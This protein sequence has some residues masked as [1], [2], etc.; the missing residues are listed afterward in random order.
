M[1]ASCSLSRARWFGAAAVASALAAAGSILVPL[2]AGAWLS[3]G[4]AL[5]AAALAAA[6]AVSLNRAGRWVRET[7]R[8]CDALARGDFE[9]RLVR[10]D[11][12]G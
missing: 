3:A 8:V 9:Q 12:G 7:A 5:L 2:A 10:I 4:L 1:I 11:E 6:A